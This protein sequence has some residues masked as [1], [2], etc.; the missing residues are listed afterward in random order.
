MIL[1]TS[2]NGVA[3]RTAPFK[4]RND[5]INLD[6]DTNIPRCGIFKIGRVSAHRIERW[7]DQYAFPG[8]EIRLSPTGIY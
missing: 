7:E 5:G 8:F 4:F 3:R 1:T 2:G 6:R